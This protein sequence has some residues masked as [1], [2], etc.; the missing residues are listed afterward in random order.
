MLSKASLLLLSLDIC[1]SFRPPGCTAAHCLYRS[2]F[3]NP[4]A[5]S[6]SSQRRGENQE[7]E[8]GEKKDRPSY[9]SA[10]ARMGGRDDEMRGTAPSHYDL[11]PPRELHPAHSLSIVTLPSAPST[12]SAQD[13]QRRQMT[14]KAVRI[15][16]SCHL[17]GGELTWKSQPWGISIVLRPFLAI[18]G[19]DAEVTFLVRNP[20]EAKTV[21]H[22]SRE[23]RHC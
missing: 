1:A 18:A 6:Y 20:V 12:G 7:M 23:C 11:V 4:A 3:A 14:V 5:V 21:P 2:C 15:V 10:L 8:G 22:A 16:R 19:C 9:L 13:L 17:R